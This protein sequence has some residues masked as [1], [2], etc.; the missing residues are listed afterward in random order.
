MVDVPLETL[1]FQKPADFHLQEYL[2]HSL[3]IFHSEEAPQR[4]LIRFSKEV[5]RYLGE[6]EWHG[7]QKLT[8]EKDGS[9][10]AEFELISLE[11]IKS[12]AVSFGAIAVVEEP[13]ELRQQIRKEIEQLAEVYLIAR[14]KGERV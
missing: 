13:E 2:K 5:A 3:G 4:V 10:L 6:H 8:R 11:E 12:W 1:K 14:K 9:T 7:S